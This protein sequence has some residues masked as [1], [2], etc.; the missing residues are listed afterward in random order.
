[1]P[2]Y[3]GD[4]LIFETAGAGGLG[5]PLERDPESV[6][7]DVSWNLIS[8]EVA[9]EDY[10]VVLNDGGE[11]EVEETKARREELRSER[12]EELPQFDH[13]PLPSL[14]EQREEVAE[15]RRRFDEWLSKELG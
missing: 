9:E 3:E 1:V 7:R 12:S 14:E 4:R 15:A 6:A 13:G 10:G 11:V 2:V 8:Q 5:D